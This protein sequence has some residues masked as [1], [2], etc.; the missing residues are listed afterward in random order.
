VRGGACSTHDWDKTRILKLVRNRNSSVVQRW[1]T[2]WMIGGFESR[3]G[4]GIFFPTTASRTAL[5]PTQL[6]IQWVPGA[7]S[8]GVKRPGV[9]LTAHLHLVPKSIM[10]GAIPPLPQYAFMAWCS[11]KAVWKFY[12][13]TEVSRNVNESDHLGDLIVEWGYY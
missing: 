11:E 12:L 2:G 6:L 9:K 13:Y 1:A 4:L 3:Q 7:L 10:R 8:L 5:E